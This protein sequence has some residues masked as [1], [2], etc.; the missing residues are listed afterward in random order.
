MPSD[1]SKT[2]RYNIP[3][4]IPHEGCGHDCVFCNQKKITG[5]QTSV[6]PEQAYHEISNYL[7]TI[8]TD[9][10]HIEIAYFGG[11]FT[12]LSLELQREFLAVAASFDDERIK[13]IRLSTRPDYIN[14]DILRQCVEFGVKTI[15][16][17][18]QSA[19]DD[20]LLKNRRGH[21]FSDVVSAADMIKSAGIDLGLQMMVG[22]Y[23]SDPDMDIETCKKII[24]LQPT[25]TRIY[26]TLVL[27]GTY[28]E[29]LYNMGEYMPYTTEQA[30]EVSKECLISFRKNNIDVI[31]IGLY[32]GEDLRSEGNIVAGPFHSAFGELVENRVYRDRIEADIIEKGLKNCE[33]IVEAPIGE[34][35]KIIGQRACNRKYFIEKYG[36]RIK[37]CSK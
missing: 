33:Y 8:K 29:K 22:M 27:K 31:R 2:R 4:F 23:G 13:G 19:N 34:T 21:T 15:E 11:S 16:L 14:E 9:D 24:A 7:R 32:P 10:C 25:C 26:P 36:I 5:V 28:L 20:V 18:V 30:I 17:G 37:I 1:G 3:L 35:S 12:G 6:T